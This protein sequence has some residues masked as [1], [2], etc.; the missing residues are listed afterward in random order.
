MKIKKFIGK[1]EEEAI[2][3]AKAELGMSAVI[4]NTKQ[5]Q[6]SG[7]FKAFKSG[8]VE[9]T[10]A[11]DENEYKPTAQ[12]TI[13]SNN[14]N[15]GR[16]NLEA[17][18]EIDIKSISNTT[19]SDN[20]RAVYSAPRP[21]QQA[22]PIKR[23]TP[24][25]KA[26]NVVMTDNER[27]TEAE[28]RVK[29]ED[30][31]NGFE[32]KLDNLQ[33]M[34]EENL[35]ANSIKEEPDVEA[36]PSIERQK[37]GVKMA[38][39]IYNTLL[40]N[41]VN[42]R[43]ANILVEEMDKTLNHSSNIELMLSNVYQKMI[44]KFGEPSIITSARKKPKIIFFIG[45]TGVGKTTTIAKIASKLK[46]EDG[47]KISLFTADTYRIAAEDQL[48]TYANILDT[49]LTIIYSADELNAAIE[50]VHDSDFILVDTAGFSHR[51]IQQKEDTKEL[52]NSVSSNVE[53]EVYLVL[54]ATTKYRDLL[55]IVDAYKEMTEFKL[56]FTKL[57]ETSAYGNLFNIKMYTKADMS[58]VTTGQ[59]V[60]DDIEVFDTQRI[61]K[62]LLGGK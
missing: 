9:V 48:R 5:I 44:L 14:P 46:I 21:I 27:I 47:K 52:I 13:K 19:S 57:D 36:A 16:I 29:K 28:E 2:N 56:I 6:P 4:M 43:Y 3:K 20:D 23:P 22:T 53:K 31:I 40:D 51:S 45:P 10:A 32:K 59:N 24:V 25:I 1:T 7:F 55:E 37:E 49:P 41:E 11:I 62:R 58:Y 8:S 42:E 61:V 33:S 35:K 12:E 30:T 54:S 50:K 15:T 26:S 60:P 39:M 34:L 18:D 17:N 38:K